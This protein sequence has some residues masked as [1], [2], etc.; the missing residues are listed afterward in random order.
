MDWDRDLATW[1]LNHLS[2]RV[3]SPPHRWH[4]QESGSGPVI[5]LLHGAGASTHTWRHLFPRL[6][7]NNRVVAIDL[8]G[9]GFTRMGSPARCGLTAMSA[10]IGTLCQTL[11][12]RPA[13]VVGHS[14][15]GAI[16]LDLA[17]RLPDSPAVVTIN[18][19]LG[20]FDGMAGWLFP[21]LAKLLAITPFTAVAFTAGGP[22]PA[23]ARRLIEGTGSHIDAD[24]LDLY[25]RLISDPSHVDA[26]LKMM[27]QWDIDPLLDRL[28][29]IT[30][31]CLLLTGSADTAVAPEVS[32]RATSLIPAARNIDLAGL[33]HL[34]HEE[35]PDTV[36][37][38]IL[39]WLRQD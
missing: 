22:N 33:G 4:I 37:D 6:E 15:G 35:A 34:A 11:D 13:L 20:R 38:H 16:A 18:A 39:D 32:A 1:P 30:A 9:Q 27:S 19:A 3:A 8:P 28:S 21:L 36:S 29:D 24:G 31:R 2:R 7:S 25:A 10:D 12:L 17:Q 23:R 14:A 26:T 5:L